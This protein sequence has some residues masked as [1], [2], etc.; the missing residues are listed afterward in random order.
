MISPPQG[1]E[2]PPR[3]N[4]APALGL[5]LSD[6][7]DPRGSVICDIPAGKVLQK[8]KPC[9]FPGMGVVRGR[10]EQH[11]NLFPWHHRIIRDYYESPLPNLM[12][13]SCLREIDKIGAKTMK[14]QQ[15]FARGGTTNLI[16]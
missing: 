13:I 3:C 6:V 4:E 7:P 16:C 10:F 15:L 14:Y 11:I 8:M 5:V 9:P 2:A 1:D 12:K